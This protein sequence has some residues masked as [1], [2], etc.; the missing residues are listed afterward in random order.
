MPGSACLFWFIICYFNKLLI[1]KTMKRYFSILTFITAIA[2]LVQSCDIVDPPYKT[3]NGSGGG[4]EGLTKV[5][6]EDY[7]GHG[8]VNCPQAAVTAEELQAVYGDQVVIMSV[9]AGWFATPNYGGNPLF[10]DDFTTEAGDT[11]DTYFGISAAGNPNGMVNRVPTGGNYILGPGSWGTAV[12][13]LVGQPAYATLAINTEY[14]PSNRVLN[15]ETKTKFIKEVLGQ[16]NLLVCITEDSLVAAQA[17][18]DP[19]IGPVPIDTNYVNNHVLRGTVNGTWGEL[20]S[21]SDIV[22]GYD[23]INTYQITLDPDWIPKHCHLVAFVY[24]NQVKSLLQVAEKKV[25]E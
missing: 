3:A 2:F 9:H 8:C 22:T 18:N 23:Y 12:A 5:L 11:W 1:F 19:T 4:E 6:I 16:F 24:D 10:A 21:D 14:N 13:A 15:I 25:I 7:T 20:L 17:N